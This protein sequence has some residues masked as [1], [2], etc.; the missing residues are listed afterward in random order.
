MTTCHFD[1]GNISEAERLNLIFVVCAPFK[2][3]SASTWR[4]SGP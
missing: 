2:S 4:T 1:K 3:R